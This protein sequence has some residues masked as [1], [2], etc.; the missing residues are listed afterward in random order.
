MALRSHSKTHE[1]CGSDDPIDGRGDDK[2][3][4][5]NHLRASRNRRG[6]AHQR[7]RSSTRK[8]TT[9]IVKLELAEMEDQ[10]HLTFVAY[11]EAKSTLEASSGL[12]PK[13]KNA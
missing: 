3:S 4:D 8:R 13:T 5:C 2:E 11:E 7:L 9:P 12:L 6:R 1:S 10:H